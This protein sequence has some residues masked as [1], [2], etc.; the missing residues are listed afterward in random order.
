MCARAT[1]TK[2]YDTH[3]CGEFNLYEKYVKQ[4]LLFIASVLHSG[5]IN[6]D[7]CAEHITHR[8]IKIVINDEVIRVH[9]RA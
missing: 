8:T 5:D 4:M 3:A 7:V 6:A 9:V 2:R 1:T